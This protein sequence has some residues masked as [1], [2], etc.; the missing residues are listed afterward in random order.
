VSGDTVLSATLLALFVK[1]LQILQN[2]LVGTS[3][4]V[5]RLRS[6]ERVTQRNRNL[7]FCSLTVTISIFTTI[8]V[9]GNL[10]MKIIIYMCAIDRLVTLKCI[11]MTFAYDEGECYYCRAFFILF[12]GR[13]GPETVEEE[14]SISEEINPRK[15]VSTSLLT[16]TS[17]NYF[18]VGEE[19]SLYYSNTN[20]DTGFDYVELSH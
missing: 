20:F 15:S 5:P 3:A 8:A 4:A 19:K 2:Q 6:M 10:T 7:L 16:I 11:T 17:T 1:P 18:T 9:I 13:R 14:D 12:Q